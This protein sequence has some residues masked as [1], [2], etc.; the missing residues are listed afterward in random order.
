MLLN[1]LPQTDEDLIVESTPIE[2]VISNEGTM[3]LSLCI[4]PL[5]DILEMKALQSTHFSVRR[6]LPCPVGVNYLDRLTDM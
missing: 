1:S 4:S 3:P 5:E 2:I 6:Q